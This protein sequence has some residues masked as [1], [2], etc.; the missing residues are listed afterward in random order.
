MN[1]LRSRNSGFL[2]RYRL[3]RRTVAVAV[4]GILAAGGLA[5]A[6]VAATGAPQ[7]TQLAA[8]TADPQPGSSS[9]SHPADDRATLLRQLAHRSVRGDIVV[10]TKQGFATM[11]FQRGEVTAVDPT[12]FTV[13]DATGTTETWTLTAATKI[14]E[15]GK[16]AQLTVGVSV[17]VLGTQTDGAQSGATRDARFVWILAPKATPSPSSA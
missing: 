4:A 7:P 5:G 1:I 2:R 15:R 10:R 13:R 17:V 11:S 16:A 14:R 3:G 9:G 12:T 8:L 6:A